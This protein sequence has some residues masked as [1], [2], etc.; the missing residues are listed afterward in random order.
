MLTINWPA[1]AVAMFLGV[2]VQILWYSKAL[3]GAEWQRLSGLDAEA[4]QQGFVPRISLAFVGCLASAWCLAGF[5]N[6]T[7]SNNFL[8]GSLAGLQLFL[9]LLAPAMAVEHVS[10]RRPL[11]LLLINLLPAGLVLIL[12][13]GL[14]AVWK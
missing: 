8:E 6:F 2:F 7:G 1:V 13:G 9:G 10:A 4:L 12:Q 3:A 11:N 5:F 14:L